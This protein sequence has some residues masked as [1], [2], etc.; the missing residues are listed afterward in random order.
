[1]VALVENKEADS[2]NQ[3][4]IIN[5][6]F[7]LHLSL[8]LSLSSNNSLCGKMEMPQPKPDMRS[9]FLPSTIDHERRTAGLCPV[10][11]TSFSNSFFW[12]EVEWL[13]QQFISGEWGSSFRRG[14][15]TL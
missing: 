9:V 8:S 5:R 6:I 2:R 10:I 11:N 12:G 13:T 7:V 1:M 3:S 14:T 4:Q 15:D